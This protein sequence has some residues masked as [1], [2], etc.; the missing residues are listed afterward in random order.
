MNFDYRFP[1]FDEMLLGD[2]NPFL[3]ENHASTDFKQ[4][5]QEQILE[6]ATDK[7]RYKLSFLKSPHTKAIMLVYNVDKEKQVSQPE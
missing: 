3:P 7:G 5:M 2:L 4:R 6:P 1:L